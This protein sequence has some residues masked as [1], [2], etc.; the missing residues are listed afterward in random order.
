MLCPPG[1]VPGRY[2]TGQA[3]SQAIVKDDKHNSVG[4]MQ[5]R[6]TSELICNSNSAFI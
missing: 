1:H 4:E 5:I 3:A 6:V 2:N